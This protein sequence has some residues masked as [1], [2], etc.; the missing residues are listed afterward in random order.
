MVTA[1]TINLKVSIFGAGLFVQKVEYN[2]E[3][4][5][6]NGAL[7]N[8]IHLGAQRSLSWKRTFA[9][10]EVSQSWRKPWLKVPIKALC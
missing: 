1:N 4:M 7:H 2:F 9:K 6:R 3:L 8:L 10:F 5:I